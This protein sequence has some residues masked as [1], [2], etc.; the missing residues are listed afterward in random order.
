MIPKTLDKD[1]TL[2]QAD[3]YTRLLELRSQAHQESLG[4]VKEWSVPDMFKAALQDKGSSSQVW[5]WRQHGG[6]RF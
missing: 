4:Q 3:G 1:F 6:A 5:L 2:M